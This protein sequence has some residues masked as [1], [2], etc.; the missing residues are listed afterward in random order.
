MAEMAMGWTLA[1]Q[2]VHKRDTDL[3]DECCHLRHLLPFSLTSTV[4][5]G[6]MWPRR[7]WA[8]CSHTAILRPC[9]AA[10]RSSTNSRQ[11]WWKVVWLLQAAK[12][13]REANLPWFI[14]NIIAFL[15]PYNIAMYP[16][17]SFPLPY[18]HCTPS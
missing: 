17:L 4:Y 16:Y 10:G 8:S 18:Q 1:A 3:C 9:A 14:E 11:L 2:C 15:L 12:E 5:A 6:P 7:M 13:H